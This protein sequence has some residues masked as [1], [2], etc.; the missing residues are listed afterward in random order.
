MRAGS[1]AQELTTDRLAT[2]L[3]VVVEADWVT[4]VDER[5]SEGGDSPSRLLEAPGLW[6]ARIEL[7]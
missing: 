2:G 4:V 6:L 3:S 5:W 1:W 7:F